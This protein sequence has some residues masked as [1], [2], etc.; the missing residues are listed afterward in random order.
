LNQRGMPDLGKAVD[1]RVVETHDAIVL[2]GQ[3]L[4]RSTD[5]ELAALRRVVDAKVRDPE[6]ALFHHRQVGEVEPEAR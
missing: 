1:R 5:L 6:A 3:I 4:D 2:V